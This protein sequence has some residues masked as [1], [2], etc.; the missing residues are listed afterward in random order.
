MSILIVIFVLPDLA[1]SRMNFRCNHY[2]RSGINIFYKIFKNQT[3]GSLLARYFSVQYMLRFTHRRLKSN[4]IRYS[5]SPLNFSSTEK[6][7]RVEVSPVVFPVVTISRSN[8]RMILPE[9]V[10]GRASVNRISSGF[11]LGPISFAT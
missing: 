6:S 5:S 8:L 2:P 11:A 3:P 1:S 4:L 9:R 10:L 7:S